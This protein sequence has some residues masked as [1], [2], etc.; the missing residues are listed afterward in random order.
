MMRE[1]CVV[2]VA[3]AVCNVCDVR[4]ICDMRDMCILNVVVVWVQRR[5]VG[6]VAGARCAWRV[7]IACV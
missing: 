6:F 7:V 3:R 5:I 4:D 2:S 1:A